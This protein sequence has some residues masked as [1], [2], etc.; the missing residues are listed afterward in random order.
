[1]KK[2][3]EKCFEDFTDSISTYEYHTVFSIVYKNIDKIKN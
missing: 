2:D 1:M 3:F